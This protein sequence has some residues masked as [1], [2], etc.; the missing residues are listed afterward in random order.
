MTAQT[1]P[2]SLRVAAWLINAPERTTFGDML[3][4]GRELRRLHAENAELAHGAGALH[5]TLNA[6]RE[7]IAELDAELAQLRSRPALSDEQIIEIGNEVHRSMPDGADAQE[8]LLAIWREIKD[9]LGLG[10]T[11]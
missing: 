5:H 3:I 4:A 1:Q 10:T 9:A 6:Q 2:E 8:E 11:T 7:R